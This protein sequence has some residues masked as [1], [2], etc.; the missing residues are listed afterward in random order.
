MLS[1]SISMTIISLPGLDAGKVQGNSWNWTLHDL[2][3]NVV[4]ITDVICYLLFVRWNIFP[5]RKIPQEHEI[6]GERM[7]KCIFFQKNMHCAIG[8]CRIFT[9]NSYRGNFH[10]P[11]LNNQSLLHSI[12]RQIPND[13]M[14]QQKIM[15][16]QDY[17]DDYLRLFTK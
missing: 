16:I 8:S 6:Q 1:L 5:H 11:P 13:F 12:N 4:I 17:F 14:I 15:M 9:K 7:D 2:Q 3:S 10:Q